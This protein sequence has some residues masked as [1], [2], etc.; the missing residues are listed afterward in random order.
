VAARGVGAPA[1]ARRRRR[2]VRGDEE[3]LR[4]GL[5]DRLRG[6]LDAEGRVEL[7]NL[8]VTEAGPVLPGPVRGGADIT[9]EWAELDEARADGLTKVWI[10]PRR[11]KERRVEVR[12]ATVVRDF[13]E[14]TRSL[15]V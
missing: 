2:G 11:A 5:S 14:E 9:L 7:G 4:P 13:I 15:S 12:D 10:R 8:A 3:A 6:T 1:G